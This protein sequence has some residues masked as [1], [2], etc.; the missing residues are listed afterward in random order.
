MTST[1]E[2]GTGP[3][4]PARILVID[5]EDIIHR[6]L[7]KILGRQGHQV[8]SA[9]SAQE[10]LRKMASAPYDLVLTDL[11][12]PEMN[13]I[14]L[15][16]A[17]STTEHAPPAIMITGYPTIKTAVQALRLGA[18]DYLAKPFTRDELLGPVNRMLRR[19]AG[20]AADAKAPPADAAVSPL[21][22]RV[23]LNARLSL[24]Y[25]KLPVAQEG[26]EV[27]DTAIL[28]GDVV[29]LPEHAW[30]EF[31]Q[32]GTFEIGVE[33]SFLNAIDAIVSVGLPDEGTLMEQG[34]VFARLR[35]TANEVHSVF[36][37][38]SGQ[39]LKVNTTLI[40][41]PETIAPGTWLVRLIPTQLSAELELLRVR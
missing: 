8:E 7:H 25:E 11:M 19:G 20:A 1:N 37:P 30:A 16:E 18:V 36:A 22:A 12:M 39:V 28:P 24:E 29:F 9:F 32:D 21:E 15:L 41:R 17:M 6:S 33:V 35:T 31:Q 2:Q 23:S 34:Y 5:D 26:L 3:V 4:A 14:Q 38:L 13:G 27:P 40:E 10:G